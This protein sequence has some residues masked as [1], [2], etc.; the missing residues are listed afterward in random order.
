VN[1]LYRSLPH[2]VLSYSAELKE[3]ERCAKL[4]PFLEPVSLT[5]GDHC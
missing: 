2:C 3:A 1:T 5:G 4:I